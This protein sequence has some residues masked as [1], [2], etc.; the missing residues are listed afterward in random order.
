MSL[1]HLLALVSQ[2]FQEI[3][4]FWRVEE[5][6]EGVCDSLY[7]DCQSTPL[8][9]DLKMA[10]NAGCMDGNH[11]QGQHP[12]ADD[13]HVQVGCIA[14]L[15]T[16][17]DDPLQR[18]V[19]RKVSSAC[20]PTHVVCPWTYLAQVLAACASLFCRLIQSTSNDRCGGL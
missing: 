16:F 6:D 12:A 14:A 4:G 11:V 9:R 19:L 3:R 5:I 8:P 15:N 10:Y 7:D 2:T 17:I 1:Q 20:R 13:F 18:V